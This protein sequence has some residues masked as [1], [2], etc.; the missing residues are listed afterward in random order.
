M[1][2]GLT[3]QDSLKKNE[4]LG[5]YTGELITH[6]EANERGRIEDRIGS[7]YLFTLNDQVTSE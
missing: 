6:D 2:Y 7:S 5:E 3:R 1:W 4:Y